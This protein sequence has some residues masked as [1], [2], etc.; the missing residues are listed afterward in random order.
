M[1]GIGVD[2]V[3]PVHQR[4]DLIE[5]IP[6]EER[7]VQH[8]GIATVWRDHHRRT[9]RRALDRM[10][11]RHHDDHRRSLALGNQVVEDDVRPSVRHPAA[12]RLAVAVKQVVDGIAVPGRLVVRRR[13][14]PEVPVHAHRLRLVQ[15]HAHVAV[16]H[17]TRVVERRTVAG[18]LDE[19]RDRRPRGARHLVDVRRI[20]Q[21]DALD[22][23]VVDPDL[24]RQRTNRDAPDAVRALRHRLRCLP[25]Q[26]FAHQFDPRRIRGAQ[27]EGD[28]AVAV[29]VRRLHRRRRALRTG[30]GNED[31]DDGCGSRNAKAGQDDADLYS[32]DGA[33]C[34]RDSVNLYYQDRGYETRAVQTH[35]D[36]ADPDRPDRK[37]PLRGR[38]APPS[39]SELV[40]AFGASRPTVN[41][42]LRE[43]QLAGLIDRRAGS[44][45]YVRADAGGR[46]YVFGLLIPELGRTEIFEPI[47]RGMAEAQH[48]SQHV[49]L[50]GTFAD[51]RR[52]H[53]GAGIARLPPARGQEGVRRLFRPVGADAGKGRDQPSHREH[54]RSGRHP[55]RAARSRPRPVSGAKP[56]RSCRHRQPPRRLRAR[57][58]SAAA[59]LPPRGLRRAPT[60]GPDRGRAD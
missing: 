2:A 39:E 35:E 24:G 26:H 21:I 43:L 31:E 59:R 9:D 33:R 50:W 48:G 18:H 13:V 34:Q 14:D 16:R 51:R 44:G 23:E 10:A 49:L 56:V 58:A 47:C 19:A 36:P 29:H 32:N 8:P 42:A 3:T 25:L 7:E 60:L 52:Q 6:S 17:R 11:V 1:R 15:H 28:T 27:P 40:K 46:G 12:L 53:R 55:P 38:P 41:R 20:G 4:N 5:Q 37:R 54:L 57:G 22:A 30:G 45:S